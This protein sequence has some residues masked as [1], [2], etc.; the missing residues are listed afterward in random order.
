MALAATCRLLREVLPGPEP[1]KKGWTNCDKR[2]YSQLVIA[3]KFRALCK[4]ER[5][6]T[7]SET[8]PGRKGELRLVCCICRAS[9][10]QN[11]FTKVEQR[12]EPEKR[13]CIGSQ[14][15]LQICPH[16]RVTYAGLKLQP[17]HIVCNSMHYMPGL[18]YEV[19]E[20]KQVDWE[21]GKEIKIEVILELGYFELGVESEKVKKKV[22]GAI[23]RTNWR[24]C[25]HLH[26]REAEEYLSLPRNLVLESHGVGLRRRF[27]R[28][29]G[30]AHQK[31]EWPVHACKAI[32]CD[33]RLALVREKEAMDGL[34][35]RVYL[36]MK[37]ERYLGELKGADDRKWIAQIVEA[38]RLDDDR[39]L[40]VEEAG[41]EDN[42]SAMRHRKR[43]QTEYSN[44]KQREIY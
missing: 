41:D 13:I 11:Y 15:V 23:S 25:P 5:N 24:V 7:L 19:V 4:Q 37:I 29:R 42:R 9:H 44:N 17:I 39:F 1:P 40:E 14:G 22:M 32:G 38:S 43:D 35:K 8:V 3:A 6:G 30:S 21:N 33:T 12:K 28:E 27:S 2:H 34:T 10:A 36:A 18:K 31:K 20:V 26:T 16:I